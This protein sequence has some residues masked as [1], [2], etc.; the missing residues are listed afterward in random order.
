MCILIMIAKMRVSSDVS[1]R[2]DYATLPHSHYAYRTL[3]ELAMRVVEEQVMH[4]G[5][6]KPPPPPRD[7]KKTEKGDKD[8]HKSGAVVGTT[9]QSSVLAAAGSSEAGVEALG[10]TSGE[11][12]EDRISSTTNQGEPVPAG[13]EVTSGGK[14]PIGDQQYSQM[15]VQ[16][17]F[18]AALCRCR[19][20]RTQENFDNLQHDKTRQRLQELH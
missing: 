6:E 10:V 14:L 13:K 4:L 7:S 18:S 16:V 1:K 9:K 12:V 19:G 8:G 20:P 2:D 17:G 11:G 3:L 5:L 15:P